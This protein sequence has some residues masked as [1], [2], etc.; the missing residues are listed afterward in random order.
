MATKCWIGHL[1][2]LAQKGHVKLLV[3]CGLGHPN[4]SQPLPADSVA[5]AA[6]RGAALCCS[7]QSGTQP[8]TESFAAT[9]GSPHSVA[10]LA[11]ELQTDRAGQLT[12]LLLLLSRVLLFE[13][14]YAALLQYFVLAGGIWASDRHT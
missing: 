12:V 10:L 13:Q 1:C 2:T 4:R 6:I 3:H 7:R 14:S 8:T 9:Y 11:G 5:N